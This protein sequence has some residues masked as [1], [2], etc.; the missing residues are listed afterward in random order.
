MMSSRRR[1]T[2][3]E[4]IITKRIEMRSCVQL[5]PTTM[6]AE[7]DPLSNA[8]ESN[9]MIYLDYNATTPLD[10]SAIEAM[11]ESMELFGNPSSG[12][13]IG[14][15]AKKNYQHSRQQI[16]SLINAK[17]ADNEIIILSGG[18]ESINYCLRG[19][20]LTAR[21]ITG[22]K[23]NHIITSKIE[24][25][26]VLETVKYLETIG[27]EVTYLPVD[28]TGKILPSTVASAIKPSTILC[29]IMHSNNEVGTINPIKEIAQVLYQARQGSPEKG[30]ANE[31]N[32][33]H[34][35]HID[36][37]SE[38]SENRCRPKI[39]FHSDTS[40]SLGK[41]D[42]NVQD[43]GIDYATITGHKLYAPKGICVSSSSSSCLSFMF[44]V[45]CLNY[46]F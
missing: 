24:H 42:V 2:T 40:Q 38:D 41:V 22:G 7:M 17:D 23:G 16:G 8:D 1:A 4:P 35:P 34:E 15:L 43:L 28:H 29:S 12:H 27:F 5:L 45:I 6:S 9:K 11:K 33:N 25:V 31:K 36:A 21:E 46:Y 20:A 39:L 32:L 30:N 10:P 44:F 19:A 18:T 14:Q 13:L 26:A 37:E 3:K